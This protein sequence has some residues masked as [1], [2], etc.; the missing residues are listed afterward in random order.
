MLLRVIAIVGP[1][2]SGKSALALRLAKK[3]DGEIVSADSRQVYR[4]LDIGSGKV[5]RQERRTIP[6]HLLDVADPKRV[7][8]VAQFV[9]DGKRAIRAVHKCKKIP[10]VVGGTGFWLDALLRGQSLPRVAPNATLRKR[11][12]TLSTKQLFA[13]LQR[14]DPERAKTID[15]HNPVRLIRALEIVLATKKPVPQR[16]EKLAYDV[17]WLGLR[18]NQKKLYIAIRKRLLQRMRQGM[19]AEVRTLLKNGVPAKRLIELGL[20]YRFVTLYL[21]GAL[22]KAAMLEQ[23][24]HAIQQYAKRQMTWFRRHKDI[25]WGDSYQSIWA[26]IKQQK[27]SGG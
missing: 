5:T 25:H 1:T 8:S 15:R 3:L 22:T 17:L 21:Q 10:I 4:G 2:A 20:E 27:R 9:Q 18:P 6:H 7:Y 11:L 14:L 24:E 19:V 12:A 13:R 26:A 23:L 16:T